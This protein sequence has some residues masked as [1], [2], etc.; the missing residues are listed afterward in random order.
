MALETLG[1]CILC[2]LR[3]IEVFVLFCFI[4]VIKLKNIAGFNCNI[5]FF[6]AC[7]V[8]K[9]HREHKNIVCSSEHLNL[10]KEATN[11]LLDSLCTR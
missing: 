11:R 7:S 2:K 3:G 5:V 9:R 6:T 8:H 10:E 4:I 1:S